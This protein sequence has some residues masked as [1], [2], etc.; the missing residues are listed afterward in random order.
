MVSNS[1]YLRYNTS[2]KYIIHNENINVR[3]EKQWLTRNNYSKDSIK[4]FGALAKDLDNPSDII[5]STSLKMS[6]RRYQEAKRALV[7]CGLLE[8]HKINSTTLVYLVGGNSIVK[9]NSRNADKELSR[10]NRLAL[11]SMELTIPVSEELVT[12]VHENFTTPNVNKPQPINLTE[13]DIL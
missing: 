12:E 9:F 13:K 1:E 5:M 4:V 6:P 7:F 10:V 3:V 8:V 2:M 11:E